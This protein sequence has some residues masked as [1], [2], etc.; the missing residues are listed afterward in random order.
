MCTVTAVVTAS[1]SASELAWLEA[2]VRVVTVAVP[3]AVG[4]FALQRPH[5]ERFGGLLVVAGCVW[6]LATLANSDDSTL[7]S[8][9]RVTG[10]MFEPL[11]IYLLLAFPTGRLE[12]GFDRALVWSAV[13]LVVVLYLPTALLVEAYPVPS[14]LA[15]CDVSCP[16]NAFMVSG[17]EPGVIEDLVRPLR[18]F[19]TIALFAAVT[20]RL[21]LR[22]RG[23]TRLMRRALTPV[24][25]VAC[26]RCAVF[27]ATPPRAAARARV[28]R[29]R[30]GRVAARPDGAADGGRVPRGSRALVGVHRRARPSGWRRGFARIPPRRISGSRWPRRSTIRRWRSCTGWATATATGVT[31]TGTGAIRLRLRP[32][33]R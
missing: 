20:V 31:R 6:F 4:A 33:A 22:I 23:S 1:G 14:P 28:R 15:S 16:G 11:L 27:A 19:M 9:G 17:S 2:V 12:S 7:Y 30:R 25:A 32:V 3:L 8:I 26:F 13:L 24:L 10:W 29:R 5:F 18:E 21:A